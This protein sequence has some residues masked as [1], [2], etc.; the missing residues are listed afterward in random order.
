MG[1]TS[2]P[3]RGN[4]CRADTR[5]FSPSFR[6]EDAWRRLK[7]AFS[8]G[9]SCCHTCSF[10]DADFVSPGH[11]L[12]TVGT[13][14]QQSADLSALGLTAAHAYAVIGVPVRCFGLTQVGLTLAADLYQSG[15]VRH[16]RVRNPW[17]TQWTRDMRESLPDVPPDST[18]LDLSW[19]AICMHFAFLYANWSPAAFTH[20]SEVSLCVTLR[21]VLMAG[22]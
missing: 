3:K 2:T 18:D 22:P 6:A 16:V 17:T 20:Q 1:S 15:E 5:S 12:I 14:S 10:L 13:G 19:E 8:E 21:L 11:C 7:T 4:V 9:E